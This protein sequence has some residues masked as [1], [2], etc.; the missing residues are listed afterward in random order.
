MTGTCSLTPWAGSPPSLHSRDGLTDDP[1]L[2]WGPLGGGTSPASPLRP[3]LS[4]ERAVSPLAAEAPR[5]P[6]RLPLSSSFQCLSV[7]LPRLETQTL[8]QD[9]G[10]ALAPPGR[11]G[12]CGAGPGASPSV[13][14]AGAGPSGAG[15][16]WEA[17]RRGRCRGGGDPSVRRLQG[18]GEGRGRGGGREGPWLSWLR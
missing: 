10:T 11:R 16:G 13:H 8:S 5:P 7:C 9:R 17:A 18:S 2:A 15:R 3:G 6:L 1:P 14:R 4:E 12:R